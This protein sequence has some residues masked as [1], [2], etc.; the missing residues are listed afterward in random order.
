MFKRNF[1]KMATVIM[2][3]AMVMTTPVTVLAESVDTDVIVAEVNAEENT[4]AD[5]DTDI[6][7]DITDADSNIDDITDTDVDNDNAHRLHNGVGDAFGNATLDKNTKQTSH[8]DDGEVNDC[9]EKG[10]QFS[11]LS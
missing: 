5:S 6:D 7:N 10:H 4:D 2:S 1:T 3:A 8:K 9:T 11:S